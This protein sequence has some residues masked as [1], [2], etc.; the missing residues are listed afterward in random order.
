MYKVMWAKISASVLRQCEV[1]RRL[2]KQ[3][4]DECDADEQGGME[5]EKEAERQAVLV[6]QPG[7][8]VDQTEAEERRAE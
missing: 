5:E 3:V 7:R 8:Q 6:G 4:L 1:L 2:W